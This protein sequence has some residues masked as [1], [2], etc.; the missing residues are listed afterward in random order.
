MKYLANQKFLLLAW[1]LKIYM[2]EVNMLI[3]KD[4]LDANLKIAEE[5]KKRFSQ[6][7]IYAYD[8]LGAIGSGKTTLI[9]KLSENLMDRGYVVGA[10]AGDVAGTDDYDRFVN[11]GLQAVNINTGKECHLDAHMIEHAIDKLPL[12]KID[13]L[14]IE[15]VGNLVCP[16]DFPL[17]SAKRFVVISVT[18]G[19]DMVRKHPVIFGQSDV[20][21]LNKIDLAKYIDVD[22]NKI[23]SDFNRIAPHSKIILTDAKHDVGVNEVMKE[24][25]SMIEKDV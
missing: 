14:F 1:I 19:N 7:G 8:I 15:N 9:E 18:E 17:G 3:E 16:A 11:A 21:I 10:I 5:N 4:I 13:I 22:T 25:L 23:V 24:I 12:D 6:Y 2:H 20:T